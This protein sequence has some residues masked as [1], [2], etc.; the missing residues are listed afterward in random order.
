M[1]KFFRGRSPY[2]LVSK[3][4]FEKLS[5]YRVPGNQNQAMAGLNYSMYF[6]LSNNITFFANFGAFSPSRVSFSPVPMWVRVEFSV[7]GS[8]AAHGMFAVKGTKISDGLG[9]QCFSFEFVVHH[10]PCQAIHAKNAAARWSAVLLPTRCL[11][12]T[13]F[14]TRQETHW[15]NIS[16][17]WSIGHELCRGLRLSLFTVISS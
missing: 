2:L 8:G 4:D 11:D 15:V 12:S 17:I 16:R 3:S 13:E 9:L 14:P 7:Y 1:V 6:S 5:P 10:N